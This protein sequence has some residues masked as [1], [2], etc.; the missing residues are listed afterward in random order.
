MPSPRTCDSCLSKPPPDVV[1]AALSQSVAQGLEHTGGHVDGPGGAARALVHNSHRHGAAVTAGDDCIAAAPGGGPCAVT[2]LGRQSGGDGGKVAVVV[3]VHAAGS[4]SGTVVPGQVAAV[5]GTAAGGAAA[6]RAAG[7]AAAGG[8]ALAPGRLAAAAAVCC[9]G[10][11]PAILGAAL[12]A[13]ALGVD[14]GAAGAAGGCDLDGTAP[15]T[16]ARGTA[17]SASGAASARAPAGLAA[18]AA[19]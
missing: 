19:V 5:G 12:T 14:A 9:G 1:D 16:A 7:G 11:A 2:Q 6:G 13:G 18:A 15:C 8:A 4:G 3:D 17:C 10:A